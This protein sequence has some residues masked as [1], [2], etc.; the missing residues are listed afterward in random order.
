MLL[1]L[2]P[3]Q[4]FFWVQAQL[5]ETSAE[6]HSVREELETT[7]AERSDLSDEL[8][9]VRLGLLQHVGHGATKD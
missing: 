8:A 1:V 5:S 9:Q 3:Q 7:S 4:M 6:L 2:P